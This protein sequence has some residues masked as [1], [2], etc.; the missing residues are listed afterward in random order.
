M[1][2][3]T[4][5]IAFVLQAVLVIV[6]VIIFS[7]LDPFDILISKKLTMKD[8]PTI[9]N[10]I[11]A[12]GK[13]ITAEY[14]GEVIKASGEA[15]EISMDS[16]RADDLRRLRT[17]MTDVKEAIS[18]LKLS[19]DSAGK[20]FRNRRKLS[21]KFEEEYPEII[22]NPDYEIVRTLV[23]KT[24]NL[25]EKQMLYELY[26]SDGSLAKFEPKTKLDPKKNTN[27][28]DAAVAESLDKKYANTTREKRRIANNSLVLLGRGWVKA[29]F[30]FSNFDESNFNYIPDRNLVR[31]TNHRPQIISATINPWF[32]PERKMKGFEYLF[33]GKTLDKNADDEDAVK[34]IQDLKTSCLDNLINDARDAGIMETAI[35]QAEISLQELFSLLLGKNITVKIYADPKDAIQ[36]DMLSDN[37]I[38]PRDIASADSVANRYYKTE[39]APVYNFLKGINKMNA[40]WKFDRTPWKGADENWEILSYYYRVADDGF[41][42]TTELDSIKRYANDTTVTMKDWLYYALT[43]TT[44]FK[45]LESNSFDT[46]KISNKAVIASV[47][48]SKLRNLAALLKHVSNLR[49]NLTSKE[50]SDCD[51]VIGRYL[52]ASKIKTAFRYAI[53]TESYMNE[54]EPWNGARNNWK[55]LAIYKEIQNDSLSASDIKKLVDGFP[56]SPSHNEYF[57]YL[58][59]DGFVAMDTLSTKKLLDAVKQNPPVLADKTLQAKLEQLKREVGLIH[60][61]H[62]DSL[63]NYSKLII[64]QKQELQD[65]TQVR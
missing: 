43:D 35:E 37:R 29:G 55:V 53:K 44:V 42:T 24:Y 50:I 8:T 15:L 52:N 38:T 60:K 36:E 41:C 54:T 47:K 23:E 17:M 25:S 34:I 32:I 61:S 33:V 21:R 10:S 5:F 59:Y 7:I 64:K 9:V 22:H 19:Y 14:Y 31:L 16:S 39:P 2:F 30:D 27:A 13:L 45:D 56:M 62:R 49:G 63:I 40:L 57:Y 1:M 6:G 4:K 48:K 46:T 12:I 11:Q 58:F 51:S 3:N 65:S 28:F 20:S 26:E 18:D